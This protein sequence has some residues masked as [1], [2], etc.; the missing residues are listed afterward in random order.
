MNLFPK[1]AQKQGNLHQKTGPKWSDFA[2]KC[3]Y[4]IFSR[5]SSLAALNL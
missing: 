2:C 3:P 5:L 4:G 1:S